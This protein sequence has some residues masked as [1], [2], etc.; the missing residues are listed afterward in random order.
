VDRPVVKAR[1][2]VLPSSSG[3]SCW[4]R[5]AWVAYLGEGV[6]RGLVGGGQAVQVFFRGG[7]ACVAE[8][9]F[10]HLQ[11]GAS[12]EKATRRARASNHES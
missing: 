8:P 2:A 7:D 1:I 3:G 10:H 9:F 4:P 12:G 11:V 6:Q 5:Q